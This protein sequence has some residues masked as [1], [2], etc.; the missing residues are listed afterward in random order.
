M[1]VGRTVQWAEY[2]TTSQLAG[3]E[4]FGMLESVSNLLSLARHRWL[5]HIACVPDDHI[6]KRMLF[7]WLPQTRSAHGVKLCRR[8]KVRQNLKSLPIS[9]PSWYEQ[10][11]D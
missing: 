5:G 10:V 3:H 4:C 1:G 2:I 9:E 11:Q 6:P 8:D 7:G